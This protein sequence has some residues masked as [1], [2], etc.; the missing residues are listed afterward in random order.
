MERR[1][2][3]RLVLI[4]VLCLLAPA[5]RRPLPTPTPAP[6]PF[7]PAASP[8]P[9]LAPAPRQIWLPATTQDFATLAAAQAV[10]P[11]PILT[12][13][14]WERL[15]PL[16]I[17]MFTETE[18]GELNLSLLY[19]DWQPT[20]GGPTLGM[21]LDFSRSSGSLLDYLARGLVNACYQQ[22]VAVRGT[23][24]LAFWDAGD[25]KSNAGVL[26]WQEGGLKISLWLTGRDA[27]PS[28]ES[29]HLFDDLLLRLA[30]SLQPAGAE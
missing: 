5:C 8:T 7:A 19:P 2:G 26:I 24:G 22:P 13:A 14:G 20:A 23:T 27:Q 15:P 12:P 11:F 28:A 16:Q 17:A 25:G 6:P 9:C 30:A 18:N 29:P 3:Y 4:A 1:P 10:V 21:T